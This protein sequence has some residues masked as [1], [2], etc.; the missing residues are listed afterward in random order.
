M[1]PAQLWHIAGQQGSTLLK[2]WKEQDER[3]YNFPLDF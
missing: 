1:H 3:K 2:S